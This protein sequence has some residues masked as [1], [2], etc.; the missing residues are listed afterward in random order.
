MYQLGFIERSVFV[1]WLQIVKQ[2]SRGHETDS[3]SDNS[4]TGKKPQRTV[5]SHFMPTSRRIVQ[6]ANGAKKANPNSKIVYIDGA[7]DVFHVGHVAIL[8]EAKAMGDF[9][10]VGLHGDEEVVKRRG[11]H[12]PIMNLHER[13]L[14]VLAC[15]HVD[16]VIIGVPPEI[17]ADLIRTFNISLVVRGSLSETSHLG[18]A[19]LG[20]YDSVQ[21]MGIYREIQS[22]SAMTTRSLIR[23]IVDNC[24]AFEARN[25]KK[26]QSEQI[27][28][29]QHKEFVE[30][31]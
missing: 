21:K 24:E 1:A 15:K 29:K 27:Y 18:A 28:Y 16:E 14:S 7:F 9:L 4:E 11:P 22:P 10:L 3:D 5:L 31:L 17:T 26:E 12:M 19:E 8:R 6:F 13:S 2:F 23:R 30:E 25:E 20:R